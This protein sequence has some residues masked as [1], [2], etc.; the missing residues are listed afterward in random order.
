MLL[1]CW[2]LAILF[3]YTEW[4]DPQKPLF[5][6]DSGPSGGVTT[7]VHSFLWVPLMLVW[8]SG[9]WDS[10]NVGIFFWIGTYLVGSTCKAPGSTFNCSFCMAR[11]GF[12]GSSGRGFAV[13]SAIPAA[14]KPVWHVCWE[15]LSPGDSCSPSLQGE[16]LLFA[17]QKAVYTA[18]QLTVASERPKLDRS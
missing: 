15:T 18:K 4:M 17:L 3:K 2:Q 12:R 14:R 13:L 5:S 10:K 7:M 1:K 8:S 6:C 9:N 11:Q 16:R